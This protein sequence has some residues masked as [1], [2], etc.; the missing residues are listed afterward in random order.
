MATVER[1]DEL[2]VW[3]KS[4]VLCREIH[5][6][7]RL[8]DFSKDYSLKD[9]IRRSS[10][11]V[12]DNIAEGFDRQSLKEFRQFLFIAKGSCS[13]VKSQLYRAVDFGYINEKQLYEAQEI[14]MQ[15]G[16]MLGGLIKYLSRKIDGVTN[17]EEPKVGYES[18]QMDH[19]ASDLP[20]EFKRQ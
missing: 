5:Q 11:S 10:G 8:P 19:F 13:E 9:Q 20:E 17:V 14:A 18:H 1:F 4:R 15:C 12:M 2:K 3:Q 7:T 16:R 6:L